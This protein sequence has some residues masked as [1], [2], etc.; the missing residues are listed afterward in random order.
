MSS[1]RLEFTYHTAAVLRL[2]IVPS[3]ALPIVAGYFV[4]SPITTGDRIIDIGIWA[5]QIA[6]ALGIVLFWLLPKILK[7]LSRQPLIIVDEE[8]ITDNQ[9]WRALTIPW[10]AIKEI[11]FPYRTLRESPRQPVLGLTFVHYPDY[12]SRVPLSY[13]LNKLFLSDPGH[14]EIPFNYLAGD[15]FDVHSYLLELQRNGRLPSALQIGD[16]ESRP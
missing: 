16:P 15:A 3:I 1:N 12:A 4:L 10:D 2:V 6:G 7:L 9:G 5:V 11:S 8:G 14:Y 13:K